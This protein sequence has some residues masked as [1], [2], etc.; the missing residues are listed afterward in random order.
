MELLVVG[1]GA[2]GRWVAETVSGD[3]DVAF[4]DVDAAVASDAAATVGGRVV[5]VDVDRGAGPGGSDANAAGSDADDGVTTGA[6]GTAGTAGTAGTDDPERFDA[7]C[8]AVP[9]P[10][11]AEAAAA[12]APRAREAVLD[13]TGAMGPAVAALRE[14]APDCE[15]ASLHPLFAPENAPG[16]VAVVRDAPGPVTDALLA[17]LEAAGNRTF[18]TTAAEHDEA[19]ETVQAAAHAATLAFALAA[20]DV[21]PEYHTPV[22]ARLTEVAR[23]VTGDGSAPGVYREIQAAFDG[24][25]RVAAAAREVAA[26][27]GQSFDDLYR[28]A[29]ARAARLDPGESSESSDPGESS[30]P[31]ESTRSDAAAAASDDDRV[32]PDDGGDGS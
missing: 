7:V 4:A 23:T 11:V 21:R 24:A 27:E 9:M 12:H 6:D 8:L 18:E 10:R 15:R 25:D 20:E 26:A 19:M 16:T 30:A 2:M 5:P 28:E 31:G 14:H 17:D 22:S 32:E 3:V 1:A 29:A 13:V